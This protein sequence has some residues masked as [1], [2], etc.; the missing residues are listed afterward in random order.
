MFCLQPFPNL[1]QPLNRLQ[2][3]QGLGLLASVGKVKSYDLSHQIRDAPSFLLSDVSQCLV[4][5][6]FQQDLRSM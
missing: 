2:S 5:L 4:L 3:V 1:G 6:G